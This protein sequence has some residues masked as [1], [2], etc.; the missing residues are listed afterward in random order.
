MK[1]QISL[2]IADDHEIFRDGLALMINK[3]ENLSLVGQAGDGRELIQLV[4]DKQPDI[5][6]TDIKMPYMDGIAATR[7]ML[8]H[9]PLL[10][11][12]AL[13]MFDEEDLIVEMLEA[14]AKGYL[15]KNADKKEI[16]EAILTVNE[17]NIFYCKLTSA[18]LASLI[19]KSKFD[20]QKK[21]SSDLFTE[22]EKQIIEL[23]CLQHTAQEIGDRLFLSKRTV[24]GYRTRILEKMEVKNTAGVVVFALRH[25][26]I[27][28][29]DIL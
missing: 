23:I 6:I 13:S 25:N 21:K 5:V 2:V 27:R 19:V 4:N 16:Q 3:Q 1:K 28:E 14:G 22:R 8:Q 17:G 9:D 20:P 24:E 26:L 11:I 10:K 7:L 12:I 15:L 29:E 18:R